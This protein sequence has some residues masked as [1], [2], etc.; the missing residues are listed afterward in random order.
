MRALCWEGVGKLAVRDVPEPRLRAD[1]DGDVIV[2]VRA[3]SVCGSDL[4]LINRP[5]GWPP[6]SA[7]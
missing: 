2:R 5:A 7:A 3:S 4:H 1:G 6:A